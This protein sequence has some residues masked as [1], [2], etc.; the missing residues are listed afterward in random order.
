MLAIVLGAVGIIGAVIAVVDPGSMFSAVSV[1]AIVV[2]H[3]ST[4][5]RTLKLGSEVSSDASS[6]LS[7]DASI[8]QDD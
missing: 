3:L 8:D 1:L 6:E 4:G 2:F 5:W 7:I